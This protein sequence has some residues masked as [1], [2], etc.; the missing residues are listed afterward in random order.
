LIYVNAAAAEHLQPSPV[1]ARLTNNGTLD[2]GNSAAR[3]D[4]PE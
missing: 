1:A 4:D 2:I 3:V